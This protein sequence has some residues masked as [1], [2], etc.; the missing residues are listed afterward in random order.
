MADFQLGNLVWKITG[1]T[2]GIK[3]ALVVINQHP[4]WGAD[5]A[6]EVGSS[7]KTIWLIR[8]HEKKQPAGSYSSDD[9]IL[10]NKLQKADNQN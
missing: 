10:L 7:P 9:L 4:Q 8:N 1:D 5:L 6:E 2:S 3:R